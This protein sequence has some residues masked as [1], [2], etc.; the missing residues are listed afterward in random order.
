MV[1]H[2]ICHLRSFKLYTLGT[3]PS[4]ATVHLQK[5]CSPTVPPMNTSCWDEIQGHLVS[6][7]EHLCKRRSSG[8]RVS[9]ETLLQGDSVALWMA[10][11]LP[12]LLACAVCFKQ[13]PIHLWRDRLAAESPFPLSA[14]L[15]ANARDDELCL[16]LYLCRQD[17]S[18]NCWSRSV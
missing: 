6:H 13:M 7:H 8:V 15:S 18:A 17:H 9:R 4:L 11:N 1:F 12:L 5:M 14:M 2:I 16:S 3:E 10:A